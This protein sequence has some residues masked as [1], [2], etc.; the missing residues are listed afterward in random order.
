MNRLRELEKDHAAA[1]AAYWAHV[2]RC[3]RCIS[4]TNDACYTEER[5]DAYLR[6]LEHRMEHLRLMGF[7]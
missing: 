4:S 5:L 2:K 1:D 3:E 6:R 7:D